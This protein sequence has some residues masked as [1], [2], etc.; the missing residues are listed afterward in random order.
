MRL[1]CL[2]ALNNYVLWLQT[3]GHLWQGIKEEM[4]ARFW[5]K[6]VDIRKIISQNT[7]LFKELILGAKLWHLD[8]FI[9]FLVI[10]FRYG[11]LICY[12]RLHDLEK[13]MLQLVKVQG[14][15]V[16]LKIVLRFL[17]LVVPMNV[18]LYRKLFIW[19]NYIDVWSRIQYRVNFGHNFESGL[20]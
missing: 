11:T 15:L 2:F 3:C 7:I 20:F 14:N 1:Y 4:E 12:M 6:K 10:I 19:L 8:Y 5:R 13:T 17:F 9:N 16:W 18:G